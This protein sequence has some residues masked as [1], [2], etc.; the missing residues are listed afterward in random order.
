M[1]AEFMLA[2]A[3]GAV[4]AAPLAPPLASV[5]AV[6]TSPPLDWS[7]S[8]R[9]G[10]NEDGDVL[11][12]ATFTPNTDYP[13]GIF[14]EIGRVEWNETR[15]YAKEDDWRHHHHEAYSVNHKDNKVSIGL[16]WRFR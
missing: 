3:M 6:P 5:G 1:L 12:G 14:L 13:V 4:P 8:G 15:S 2:F 10:V 16:E 11:I 7:L 9:L